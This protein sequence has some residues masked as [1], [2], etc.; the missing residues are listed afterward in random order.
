MKI[1]EAIKRMADAPDALRIRPV[2]WKGSGVGIAFVEPQCPR[3]SKLTVTPADGRKLT[4]DLT[5]QEICAG[6]E[7]ISV[8]ELAK[9][10][11][12]D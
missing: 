1:C 11:A 5:A 7:C 10:R 2:T 9:E 3:I 8:H 4:P 12:N 6:W